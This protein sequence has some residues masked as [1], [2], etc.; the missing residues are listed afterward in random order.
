MSTVTPT[1]EDIRRAV[2]WISEN[3]EENP[4]QVRIKII[5]QAVFKFDLSPID[6]EFLINYFCNKTT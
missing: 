1:G 5:E 6:A 4:D 2:K 3:M